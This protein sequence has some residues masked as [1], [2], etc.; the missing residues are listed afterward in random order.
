[1]ELE[2]ITR[3][4]VERLRL[5]RES[6]RLAGEAAG[7]SDAWIVARLHRS[8]GLEELLS[9]SA[10]GYLDI[11]PVVVVTGHDGNE[12][13]VIVLEDWEYPYEDTCLRI[14]CSP[15]TR[16]T[17]SW[18]GWFGTVLRPNLAGAAREPK[19]EIDLDAWA[20]LRSDMWRPFDR[21]ESGCMGVTAI[22]HLGDEVMKGFGV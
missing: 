8:V 15:L 17:G 20:T 9:F 11:E 19:A 3:V 2:T 4:P 21:P 10:N 1:M 12:S 22:N 16:T 18:T 14:G 5:D 7:A 13:G 6:P